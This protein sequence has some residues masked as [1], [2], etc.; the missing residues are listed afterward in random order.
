MSITAFSAA[1]IEKKHERLKERL[2][3][4]VEDRGGADRTMSKSFAMPRQA[5]CFTLARL[6][7]D[8]FSIEIKESAFLKKFL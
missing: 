3:Q 1:D 7:V 4:L 6:G 2:K 8:A 5:N